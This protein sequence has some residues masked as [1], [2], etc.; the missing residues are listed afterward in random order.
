MTRGSLCVFK[1][2]GFEPIYFCVENRCL[3][4][5][6][7]SQPTWK[8][9]PSSLDMVLPYQIQH[10]QCVSPC[11]ILHHASGSRVSPPVTP[12]IA[13]RAWLQHLA[14]TGL[15]IPHTQC[16]DSRAR[17]RLRVCLHP[18]RWPGCHPFGPCSMF[19]FTTAVTPWSVSTRSGLVW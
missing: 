7:I 11:G 10:I 12:H 15:P 16:M 19:L 2:I 8:C 1:I 18:H 6:A 14:L 5:S 4:R 17:C 13:R 9:C 3:N